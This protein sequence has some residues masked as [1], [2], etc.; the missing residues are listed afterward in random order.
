MRL[1]VQSVLP[2]WIRHE[3]KK[4]YAMQVRT[5]FPHVDPLQ[6]RR[7]MYVMGRIASNHFYFWQGYGRLL[8]SP[9]QSLIFTPLLPLT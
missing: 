6:A 5:P 3:Q 2:S 8:T 1:G 7:F 9:G 4:L